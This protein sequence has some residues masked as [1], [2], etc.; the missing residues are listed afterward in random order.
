MWRDQPSLKAFL[1]IFRISLLFPHIA[2]PSLIC[3]I[4]KKQVFFSYVAGFAYFC[5]NLFALSFYSLASL[6]RL[7]DW[8]V[9]RCSILQ[10][11]SE[12]IR[13]LIVSF[14]NSGIL[15]YLTADFENYSQFNRGIFDFFNLRS[16]I[17][18]TIYRHNR[19]KICSKTS[20]I[21]MF[22]FLQIWDMI[23]VD[24]Q[25]CFTQICQNPWLFVYSIRSKQ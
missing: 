19:L 12:W 1:W 6:S 3:S 13:L 20:W 15:M 17:Y 22:F 8:L 2:S 10:E 14:K 5:S 7:T 23:I 16:K 11:I 18:C 25:S 24:I 9:D 21:S 4:L